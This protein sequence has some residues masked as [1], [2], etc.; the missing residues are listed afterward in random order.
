MK[1]DLFGKIAVYDQVS[2]GAK[3]HNPTM[4]EVIGSERAKIKI[5]KTTAGFEL[6]DV[7][8]I[9]QDFY[10]HDGSPENKRDFP[11][12]V[13]KWTGYFI[14][15]YNGKDVSENM[16]YVSDSFDFNKLNEPWPRVEN[17]NPDLYADMA[18]DRFRI[19]CLLNQ[20][21]LEVNNC[22]YGMTALMFGKHQVRQML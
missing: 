6:G 15:K 20:N 3:S 18:A 1:V 9:Q 21:L 16:V 8:E 14:S 2:E 17:E 19:V 4:K 7:L 12:V 5:V 10:K 22:S 11:A 13:G